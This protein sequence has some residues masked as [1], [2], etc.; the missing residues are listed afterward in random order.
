LNSDRKRKRKA[1]HSPG[2]ILAQTGP[3]TAELCVRPRPR[4]RL[5]AGVLEVFTNRKQVLSLFNRVTDRY[6]KTTA[7]LPIHGWKSTTALAHSRAPASTSTGRLG[8]QQGSPS[9]GHKISTT[10]SISPK[11]IARMATQMLLTT[12]TAETSNRITCSQSPMAV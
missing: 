7:L 3:T 8:Q 6:K 10:P 11:S 2:L 4:W 12:V 1:M 9:S 5:C